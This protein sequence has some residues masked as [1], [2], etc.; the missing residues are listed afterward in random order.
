MNQETQV[1]LMLQGR[2]FLLLGTAHVSQQSIQ[3]VREAIESYQPDQV[4]VELDEGRYHAMMHPDQWAGLDLIKVFKEGKGFLLLANL[5]LSSFQRRLG[6]Q[7]GI[8]PGD[9]MRAAIEA[10]QEKGIPFSLCDREVQQTLKR[11]WGR[12]GFWSKNKLLASLIASA[13]TSENLE[14]ED[15]ERLKQQ[16]ELGGMMQE[17]AEYL[18]EIKETLIDERDQYLA[19]KIWASPGKKVLAILGAGHLAGVQTHLEKIA[20]G[21]KSVDI[22][23]LERLPPPGWSSKILP[24]L[25]PA[26]IILLLLAGFFRSGTSASLDM[27]FRWLLLNGSLAALGTVIALGHPLAVLV[28]FV[29]API[30]TLNPFIGVGLFSGVVQAFL[31]RPRVQDMEN[32]HRDLG[33]LRG[34]YRNRISRA[35]LVFFLSSLGGALG[36]FI[37]L[38]YLGSLLFR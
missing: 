30:A 31:R 22:A 16:N 14:A 1:K 35:L 10:A 28:S 24:W 21:N 9:E 20:Q 6:E 18:P 33:S 19:A 27:L 7:L 34:F 8:K 4:C 2:E 32:L 17:L 23:E 38:P 12:C 36:N 5:I 26:A 25:I 15:I 37:A 3:E 29:G 11:A 13:F